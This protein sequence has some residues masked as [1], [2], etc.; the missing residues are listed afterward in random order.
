MNS[1]PGLIHVAL[2]LGATASM[3]AQCIELIR[4][5]KSL[6]LLVFTIGVTKSDDTQYLDDLDALFNQLATA[7][8]FHQV[9]AKVAVYGKW[10]ALPS[11]IVGPI[12]K[13]LDSTKEYEQCY[14]N[15]CVEYDGNEEIVDATKLIAQ[16]VQMGRLDPRAITQDTIKENLYTSSVIAP[17]IIIQTGN[18]H[19]LGGFLLWDSRYAQIY[20]HDAHSLSAEKLKEIIK[21]R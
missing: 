7:E 8:I 3:A 21:K 1:T 15:F 6:N 13:L 5:A 12:K 18:T 10:Y 4:A 20:F 11:R 19:S 16:R 2:Q 14:I 17:Q 9:Q